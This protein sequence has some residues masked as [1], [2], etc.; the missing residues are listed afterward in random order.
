MRLVREVPVYYNTAGF[1]K[2]EQV[3]QEKADLK[4]KLSLRYKECLWV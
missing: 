2:T 4:Q 1:Q 3:M